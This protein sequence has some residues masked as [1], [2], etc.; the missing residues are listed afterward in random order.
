[1]KVR[2][3]RNVK[4]D[5]RLYEAGKVYEF[6]GELVNDAM[7]ILSLEHE[8]VHTQKSTAEK[9]VRETIKLAEEAPESAQAEE[10]PQAKPKTAPLG[11]MPAPNLQG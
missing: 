2:M 6:D 9:E 3:I 11:G 4:H 5:G 10:Q 8:D 1:M 7:E